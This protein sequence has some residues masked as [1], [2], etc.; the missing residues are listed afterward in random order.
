MEYAWKHKDNAI[1]KQ[2]SGENG[3][4]IIE[5]LSLD[6]KLSLHGIGNTGK[7]CKGF[8]HAV[9]PTTVSDVNTLI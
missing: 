4:L 2:E 9:S 5:Q 6:L 8:L 1:T 3:S 7:R